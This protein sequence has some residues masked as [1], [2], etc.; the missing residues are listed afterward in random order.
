MI[1]RKAESISQL[2]F[3]WDQMKNDCNIKKDKCNYD[4]IPDNW[5]D[6]TQ[7]LKITW[8]KGDDDLNL[9]INVDQAQ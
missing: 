7:K 2:S 8:W 6:I 4:R 9:L 5:L 3:H 1:P